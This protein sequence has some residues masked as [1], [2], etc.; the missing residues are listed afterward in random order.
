MPNWIKS[1]L[2][3]TSVCLGFGTIA[4]S[5]VLAGSLTNPSLSG[6]ASYL[7]YDADQTNTFKVDNTPAN[8][9]KVLSGDLN[10]PM[11]NVELFSNSET[12][13]NT[14][15]AAYTGVSSLSGQIGGRDITLSSLTMADWLS[16][17][18]S[19]TLGQTWF[20]DMLTANGF[21]TMVGSADGT[22]LFNVFTQHGGFQRFSDPNVA[23][24]NQ[25][26]ITGVIKIGLAGHLNATP[27]FLK[28]IDA[29]LSSNASTQSKNLVRA[30]RPLLATKVLQASELIKYTYNNQTGY[31]YSF[32][33]VNSGLVEKGDGVSHS[34]IYEV[35]LQGIAPEPPPQQSVP[36]PALLLGL[37]GL[38]GFLISQRQQTKKA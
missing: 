28:S 4:S 18:G 12:L 11:G 20:D 27:L 7:T 17:V 34:A 31:L 26:N 13:T 25:N 36:E 32:S 23:Y 9:V 3:G 19:K 16:P 6:A 24:V 22:L 1:F 14:A 38:G 10:N 35:A 21:G 37:A 2:L 30:L 8:L 5:P 33:G 15:F 29:F